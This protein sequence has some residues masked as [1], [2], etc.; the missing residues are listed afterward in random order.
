MKRQTTR[1]EKIFTNYIS[2]KDLVSK[3]HKEL[4]QKTIK[5]NLINK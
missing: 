2:A 5:D 1:W 3:I 4:L